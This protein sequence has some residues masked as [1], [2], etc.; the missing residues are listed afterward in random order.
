[1]N[2]TDITRI[3]CC[4]CS[5]NKQ[6]ISSSQR[7]MFFSLCTQELQKPESKAQTVCE[8]QLAGWSILNISFWFF[9]HFGISDILVP[10]FIEIFYV[11][12]D[13]TLSTGFW[14]SLPKCNAIARIAFINVLTGKDIKNTPLWSPI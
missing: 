6:F 3:L 2:I 5:E 11:G 9:L 14:R 10:V 12:F 1:M 7:V 13:R 8:L 4:F